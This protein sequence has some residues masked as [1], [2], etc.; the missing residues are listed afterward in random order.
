LLTLILVAAP[1]AAEEPANK[2]KPGDMVLVP[3]AVFTMGHPESTDMP[4]HKVQISTFWMDTFEVTNAEYH[5]FCE[6]TGHQPPVFWGLE[7]FRSSLDYPDHPVIGVSNSSAKKYAEWAGKRLPNEAEWEFAARGGMTNLR[8]DNSDEITIED[9]N[10]KKT[11][12]D[13]PVAVGSYRPNGYGLY[14]MIGNAREH[15]A[16]FW[17]V[18]E[19]N[20][21][22]ILEDPKGPEDGHWR[23][24]RGGGWFSGAMCNGV[25]SRNVLASNWSDFNVGFRC[26]KDIEEDHETE[27]LEDD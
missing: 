25:S 13:G 9:A 11:D 10:Y 2:P 8:F 26:A 18:F 14:D 20:P 24:I 15:V 4:P 5:A 16:D 17:S 21:E 23:V 12:N 22:V 1:L 27:G 3:G 6:A 19:G 7:R